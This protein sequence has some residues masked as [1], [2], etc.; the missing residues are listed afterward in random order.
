MASVP[1][2]IFGI[3]NITTDSFS[4]GGDYLDPEAA[5]SHGKNLLS[6]GAHV[7]DVGPAS[8]HPDAGDV[9]PDTEMARLESVWAGL[10]AL[11]API[12]VDSF[13]PATQRWS[14]AQGADWLND[15]NGFQDPS[16]HDELADY[17]G[18]LVVMHAI[19]AKG[20]ATREA[21][22]EGDIWSIIFRFF[23]QKL[24]TFARA[25]IARD[26]LVLDPGMGFFLGN[27]P[28]TSMAVLAGLQRLKREFEVPVLVCVSRKSF[29]RALASP[30]DTPIGV[31]QS[32]PISLAG[33]MLALE[34][35]VDFIR[36]HAPEPLTQAIRLR[37]ASQ[38][39]GPQ[40]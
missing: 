17:S 20:I 18:K 3:V 4:D 13:Q 36:T 22:P 14:M 26:K 9:S 32:G 37:A 11:G 29:L 5:I 12:S 34:Q 6:Q 30:N 31:E 16:L 8:S 38:R 24:E 28:E 15:I 27:R 40:K 7:L 23:E 33:E 25:G 39:L 19:Q 2:Q 1:T 10:K 21:P 35:Q